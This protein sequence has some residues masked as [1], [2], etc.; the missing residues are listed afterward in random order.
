MVSHGETGLLVEPGDSH[1]LADAIMELAGDGARRELMGEAG[2]IRAEKMFALQNTARQLA[3]KF[4]A[5]R[6]ADGATRSEPPVVYL[7]NAWDGAPT[8]L[9]CLRDEARLRVIASV[10]SGDVP[11]DGAGGLQRIE[12]LP[13]P[14]VVESHWLRRPDRRRE[15]ERLRPLLGDA[16]DGDEFYLQARRAVYLA[17]VLPRR[18]VKHVHAFRSDAVLC[19][20]LLKKISG[21][22]VSAAIEEAP[23]ISRERLRKILA[24]FEL[25]T[26]SDSKLAERDEFLAGDLLEL[27]KPP[28]PREL[29]LGPLRM[30]LRAHAPQPDRSPLERAWFEKIVSS[31]HA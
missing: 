20:W 21:L 5:T 8:G 28:P 16:V 1:A 17:D 25:V 14:V 7:M 31:V 22:R 24:D 11:G 3:D 9:E 4:E 23:K 15:L 2:R 12:F 30:K 6:K 26:N 10:L 27:R 19:V 18:G 13:D 29:R